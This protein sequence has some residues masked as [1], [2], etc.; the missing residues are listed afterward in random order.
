[1]KRRVLVAEFAHET[2]TFSV[3]PADEAAFQRRS[4]AFGSSVPAEFHGTNT[5]MAG[6][7]DAAVCHGWE[8][9]HTVSAAANPSGR[10]TDEVYERV[11][12]AILAPLEDGTHVDGILLAL[13]GAMVTA[14]HDDAESALLGSIRA[15]AGD[16]VPIAVT[17]DLHANLGLETAQHANI[18][19]SYKTYPHIDM[20]ERGS[21]AAELLERA[22]ADDI[23]P[24]TTMARR[25]MLQGADGGR[26]DVE[27]MI[28]L[29]KKASELES[30]PDCWS[31]SINAGFCHA[32]VADTGP[33]VTVTSRVAD[34]RFARMAEDLMDDIWE[35]RNL[36]ANE[37][38]SVDEAA[39]RA[40]AE[41]G[42]GGPVVIADYADNPGAGSYG[43]ATNLLR[44]MLHAHV[45]DA[46]FGALCD[47]KAA[48]QLI[49]CGA[50]KKTRVALGG[51]TDP[52]MGGPPL[53]VEGEV[54]TTTDGSFVYD[55]PMWAGMAAS[56]GPTA[57]FR[58]DGVDILVTS[59]LRQITDIQ[60][61]RANG[62]EP[63]RK[64][65]VAL[66]SMQHFRAA[67]EPIARCVLVCDSGA[68]ASPDLHRLEYKH[69]R[70][71][72][73]PLDVD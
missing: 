48:R 66:K 17:F 73:H 67:Y 4:Y 25:S 68:L 53:D 50:G 23:I 12:A 70:R 32:D 43:D 38:L 30:D 42:D 21:V 57:V 9:L 37:F 41:A 34:E 15:A 19:C 44:A 16:A 47:P 36:V 64:R 54:L 63:T 40:A 51:K 3:Q 46:C 45:Q 28:G 11:L 10:V 39:E 49:A 5:E 29:L 69:V 20:R 2:N 8:L 33:S 55:G 72:I 22:M 13:H 52:G 60:Q 18:V 61:F 26:T 31:V 62:I 24:S 7:M 58:V 6:F 14:S 35:T 1:M 65:A 56:M 59:Y 71:P 27:P